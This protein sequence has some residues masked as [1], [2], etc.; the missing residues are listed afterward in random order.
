MRSRLRVPFERDVL[1]APAASPLVTFLCIGGRAEPG[2]GIGP[3]LGERAG[4]L[5]PRDRA[6]LDQHL[7]ERL[8]AL[9]LG[10]DRLFELLLVM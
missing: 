8:P 10:R 5:E 1:F 6:G 4:E 3:L 7:P 9:L 2:R